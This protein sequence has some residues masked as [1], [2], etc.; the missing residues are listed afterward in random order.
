MDLSCTK[1]EKMYIVIY[2]SGFTQGQ[3]CEITLQSL[4]RAFALFQFYFIFLYL[5]S[6]TFSRKCNE[7]VCWQRPAISATPG[8]MYVN[9]LRKESAM[10][11][12]ANLTLAVLGTR[13]AAIPEKDFVS[14]NASYLLMVFLNKSRITVPDLSSTSIQNSSNLL[15]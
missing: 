10:S 4:S 14:L 7:C 13:N 15:N 2:I 5:F 1:P 8:W 6:R 11:H 3:E 12:L 9:P